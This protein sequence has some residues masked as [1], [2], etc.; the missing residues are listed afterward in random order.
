MPRSDR[1]LCQLPH[2]AMCIARAD[3]IP[4][5]Q[6][7]LARQAANKISPQWVSTETYVFYANVK[8]KDTAVLTGEVAV[9]AAWK[10][11]DPEPRLIRNITLNDEPYSFL[12]DADMRIK[13]KNVRARLYIANDPYEKPKSEAIASKNSAKK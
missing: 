9:F 4:P 10:P 11:G 5:E 2:I 6:R 3:R 7:E 12:C 13:N 1:E 8:P